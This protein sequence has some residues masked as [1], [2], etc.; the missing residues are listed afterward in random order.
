MIVAMRYWLVIVIAALAITAGCSK[1][2]PTAASSAGTGHSPPGTKHLIVPVGFKGVAQI[3]EDDTDSGNCHEVDGSA[4][5]TFPANGAINLKDTTPLR[6]PGPL[7]MTDTAGTV[8]PMA[9]FDSSGTVGTVNPMTGKV[10]FGSA[11]VVFVDNL[12]G[13]ATGMA[14]R[15]VYVVGPP[16]YCKKLAASIP[17]RF[18]EL[19]NPGNAPVQ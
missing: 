15:D 5:F 7:V 14:P 13:S 1:K 18:R 17:D 12:G 8:I 19:A 2:S 16:D 9:Y 11:P 10:T 3:I 4:D 6:R